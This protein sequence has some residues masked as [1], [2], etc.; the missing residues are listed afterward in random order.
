MFFL[1]DHCSELLKTGSGKHETGKT[2]G[3]LPPKMREKSR[4]P[5]ATVPEAN[6]K[7]HD[8]F[9]RNPH[10]SKWYWEI[11]QNNLLRDT[12][13]CQISDLNFTICTQMAAWRKDRQLKTL[14]KVWN[15]TG[16][17]GIE[18]GLFNFFH[19]LFNMWKNRSRFTECIP[20]ECGKLKCLAVW[21]KNAQSGGSVRERRVKTLQ[22]EKQKTPICWHW[23]P[24]YAI[25]YFELVSLNDWPARRAVWARH[26]FG[27]VRCTFRRYNGRSL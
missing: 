3:I 12:K 22:E 25:L 17:T 16:K 4:K 7:K 1:R 14:W 19:G 18:T 20:D 10:S 15:S 26:A 6:A 23:K 24:A 5:A 13:N 11:W 9:N 8:F 2:A 27:K 21:Q